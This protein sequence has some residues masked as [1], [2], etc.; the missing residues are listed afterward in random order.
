[1]DEGCA[2]CD[3]RGLCTRRCPVW[4]EGEALQVRKRPLSRQ[5]EADLSDIR[6]DEL[7]LAHRLEDELTQRTPR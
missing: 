2:F 1:M 3:E 7:R 4:Q 5:D 6:N